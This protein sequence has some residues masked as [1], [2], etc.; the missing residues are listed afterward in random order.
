MSKAR[1][2]FTLV[3]MLVVIAIIGLLAAILIP[4]VN[5]AR[6]S[7]RSS[8]AASNL[9]QLTLAWI[10]YGETQGEMMPWLIWDPVKQPELQRYWFAAVI[11]DG[12]QPARLDFDRGLLA[13]YMEVERDAFQDPDF[14]LSQVTQSR[15]ETLTTAFAYNASYLGPGPSIQYDSA[16]NW[17]GIY[18]PGTT[19][20]TT[21][22]MV[23]PR[24]YAFSSVKQS[25]R[26]IVFAD[27]ARGYNSDYTTGLTENWSLDPP[28]SGNPTVHFRHVGDVA[29]VSF[30]DGHV[31]K[32]RWVENELDVTAL[33]SYWSADDRQNFVAR[34]LGFI[35]HDDSLYNREAEE[36]D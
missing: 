2:A 8:V 27:S 31:K 26:T 14:T 16:W 9:R 4:A 32:F 25:A 29:N 7:A 6:A 33:P 13:A 24:S 35:G 30:A 22:K 19:H 1:T 20:P 5:N 3:E 23:P 15:F 10:Q 12:V 17:V 18:P 21:G 34:R 28:S 11:D 36:V